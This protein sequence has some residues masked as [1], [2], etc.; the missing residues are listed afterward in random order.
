MHSGLQK[1]AW[2]GEGWQR[3]REVAPGASDS[4]VRLQVPELRHFHAGLCVCA[5]TCACMHVH[6][7]ACVCVRGYVRG[8][9]RAPPAELV[10]HVHCEVTSTTITAYLS[11]RPP[12][13]PASP[14][15][16]VS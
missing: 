4:E 1:R 8:C 9:A 16:L 3:W 7:C 5:R 13:S 12:R 6:V 11:C 15:C 2:W 14:S 10:N